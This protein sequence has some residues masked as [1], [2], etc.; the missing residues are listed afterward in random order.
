MYIIPVKGPVVVTSYM[1]R[2]DG[3]YH[4]GLDIG[5]NAPESP[6]IIAADAGVVTLVS[7]NGSGYGNYAI[8]RHGREYTLYGH[9]AYKPGV[10]S[11]QKLQQGDVIGIMGETGN[12]QGR[13]LHFEIVVPPDSNDFWSADPA[14][15]KYYKNP[16][17]EVPAFGDQYGQPA[18][19]A[20]KA[21]WIA[22]IVK[23]T[24][25]TQQQVTDALVTTGVLPP[26]VAPTPPS[27]HSSPAV[28]AA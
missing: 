14:R 4:Q 3:G 6:D 27:S 25:L 20:Q 18:L 15:W 11:G 7:W 28:P 13:H 9:M 21:R 22:A 17:L 12:A 8:L 10:V 1:A 23:M 24:G 19:I 26:M 2:S 5:T 16:F